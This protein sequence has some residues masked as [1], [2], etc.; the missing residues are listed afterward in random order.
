MVSLARE[1]S[2]LLFSLMINMKCDC[3]VYLLIPVRGHNDA[4]PR[5]KCW[6]G[7]LL[8]NVLVFQLLVQVF[9]L[10]MLLL[11]LLLEELWYGGCRCGG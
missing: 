8:H 7:G 9:Y 3:D 11:L 4:V 5:V 10:L 2:P 6:C 1:F